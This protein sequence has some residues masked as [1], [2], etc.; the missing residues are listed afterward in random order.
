MSGRFDTEKFVFGTKAETLS[1]IEN[2]LRSSAVPRYFIIAVADWRERKEAVL[3]EVSHGFPQG[4]IA[5]RSSA[6]TEDGDENSAAGEFHSVL[7]VDAGDRSAI[8]HA[9]EAVVASYPGGTA[10]C[11]G[12]HQVL[13]QL[14]VEDVSMSGVIFT[15]DLNTGAPYYVINYDDLSGRTDTVTSG[16]DYESRTLY[17]HRGSVDMLHSPRFAAVLAAVQEI[18]R[19]TRSS[20]LDIEF[21][22]DHVE[23][24]HLLQVRRIT[25]QPNWNRGIATRVDDMIQRMAEF[26]RGRFAP[27]SGV[28]GERSVFGQMPDW[29]PV[30][31]IGSRPRP[32]SASLYQRLVTDRAWRV[33]RRQM[34]YAE[35][36]GEPLMVMLGGQPYI[37]VRL[38]FHS[39]LPAG[40]SRGASEKLV[41]G[42]IERL[43]ELPH[44]HD[45]VEFDVAITAYAFDFEQSYGEQCE[46]LLSGSEQAEFEDRLRELTANIL[47]GRIAP[48]AGELQKI[49]Q[50]ETR[51]DALLSDNSAPSMSTVTA[52]LEDCVE[53]GTIPFSVLARHGFI[54]Q[55]FLKSL[56]ALGVISAQDKDRFMAT[57]R[58]VAS[59]LVQHLDDVA[60]GAM[61]QAG[62]IERYGH[63]RPG[64]YDILSLRYD[65][66]PELFEGI[67]S[68]AAHS[69]PLVE[70]NTGDVL[71]A[72]QMSRIDGLLK[73]HDYEL[74][75][76][77]L[78]SYIVQATQAREYAKFVF[79]RNLSDTLEIIAHLGERIGLSREELSY[80]PIDVIL[81]SR[82]FT[83]GRSTE[84]HLRAVA[85][86]E[87]RE[88]QVTSAVQ[89]PHLV[90]EVSD[91]HIVPLL[92]SRP[93]FITTQSVR[94]EVQILFGHD[95]DVE[96]DG[97]IVVTESADPGFDW[98]FTRSIR[99]L[100]TKFGGANSHMAIRCAEFGIPAAIGCGEQIFQRIA[101]A[102]SIDL[103]CAQGM[104]NISE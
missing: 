89:L 65:Q 32:L 33:A 78:I 29:N 50:L 95:T 3:E 85:E 19:I 47:T 102:G 9:V 46:G 38:S 18:E 94:G 76:E 26:G 96:L 40:L 43:T 31:M 74:S 88:H 37:D 23:R 48:I 51:R 60:T 21:A 68:S 54:A 69:D 56:V 44:L 53:L 7:N 39:Y 22:V 1:R 97:K 10:E 27:T 4:R 17:V 72:D 11:C 34:G 15:Q 20:V 86:A 41:N 45:K 55:A 82:M 70:G 16:T 79:T 99:G 13:M 64:T 14:M 36:R 57:I 100:V 93:N 80:I 104:L 8:E 24:V 28:Y 87:Q 75:A 59:E 73:Q 62:F 58:T 30:E 77:A 52:L 101:A 67:Q 2:S 90:K 5:V 71:T 35:P 49:E 61:S 103:D 25:T 6:S 84:D 98:I 66:R 63:L 42:W 83:K 91:F 81:G 12:K 92:I